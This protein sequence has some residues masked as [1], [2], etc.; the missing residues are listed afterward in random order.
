MFA[1]AKW[2]KQ[3]IACFSKKGFIVYA[4]VILEDAKLPF[5][6]HIDLFYSTN[7]GLVHIYD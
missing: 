1:Q 6:L 4:L 7:D 5:D 3:F 2:M